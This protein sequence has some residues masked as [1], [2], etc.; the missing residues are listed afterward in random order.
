MM[1]SRKGGDDLVVVE[2]VQL[3]VQNGSHPFSMSR[4]DAR[5]GGESGDEAD[6]RRPRLGD[7]ADSGEPRRMVLCAFASDLLKRS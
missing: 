6:G 1:S 3:I 5:I 2:V 4:F 7:G